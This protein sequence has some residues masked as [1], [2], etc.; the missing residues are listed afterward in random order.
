M[1]IHIPYFH[2][3]PRPIHMIDESNFWVPPDWAQPV[4][5]DRVAWF[6]ARMR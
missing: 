3:E 6:S 5:W 2:E 4:T 1:G